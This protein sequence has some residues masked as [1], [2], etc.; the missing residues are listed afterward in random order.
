MPN[1]VDNMVIIMQNNGRT[2]NEIA[3]ALEF[4]IHG[5]E[6]PKDCWLSVRLDEED[7]R[8]Y[9][10]QTA[11]EP[12]YKELLNF[13]EQHEGI[14]LVYYSDMYLNCQGQCV[15]SGGQVLESIDRQGCDEF[16]MWN[17]ITNPMV[18]LF[19]TYLRTSLAEHAAGQVQ[20]AIEIIRYL[21]AVLDCQSFT[22]SR[23]RALSDPATVAK[24]R[25]GLTA[26]LDSMKEHAA[27]ISFDGVLIGTAYE[28]IG[29][30]N[31]MTSSE[32]GGGC[33]T[34]EELVDSMPPSDK[35]KKDIAPTA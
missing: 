17:A 3:S 12:P 6:V 9:Y 22:E 33:A 20:D 29:S 2:R 23:Y 24:T 31:N 26:M 8:R 28:S 18:N 30:E 34:L 32:E 5:R 35:K 15:L 13:S 4:A 1:E 10:F 11:W 16:L 21:Q 27:S 19:N 14:V 25:A 7:D